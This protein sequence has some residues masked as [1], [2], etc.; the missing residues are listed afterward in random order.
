[1]SS[2]QSPLTTTYTDDR[3]TVDPEWILEVMRVPNLG[4]DGEL[5]RD[6]RPAAA[7]VCLFKEAVSAGALVIPD[8]LIVV[9]CYARDSFYFNGFTLVARPA[10]NLC[11]GITRGW[12]DV[13]AVARLRGDKRSDNDPAVVKAALEF[14]ASDINA[15][16]SDGKC[17]TG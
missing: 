2:T 11:T 12:C 5:Y 6:E 14:M 7:A 1:M 16:L 10:E 3:A 17:V 13:L 8:A 9:D 15:A 4:F